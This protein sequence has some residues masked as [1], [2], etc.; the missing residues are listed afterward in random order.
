M[1]KGPRNSPAH[2]AYQRAYHAT[3]DRQ[4]Y[5]RERAEI[6]GTVGA[7]CVQCGASNDLEV[8]HIDPAT[9]AFDVLEN[10]HRDRSVLMDELAKCQLLCSA[11]HA[12]KHASSAEHGTARRY[13]RGCRCEECRIAHNASVREWKRNRAA[14]RRAA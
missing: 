3:Y 8:D 2:K 4:R 12:K 1:M 10:L 9:K 13:Y 11:C 14:A 7:C 6:I 5:Q